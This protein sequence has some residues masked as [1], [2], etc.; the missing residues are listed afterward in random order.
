[1]SDIPEN[2]KKAALAARDYLD[3]NPADWR[4]LRKSA[5][6][7]DGLVCAVISALREP[8]P[9]MIAKGAYFAVEQWGRAPDAL[10]CWQATIDTALESQVDA[11]TPSDRRG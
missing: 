3:K 8:T 9:E 1:M 2:R 5:E 7:L 11:A 6:F 10:S 4:D